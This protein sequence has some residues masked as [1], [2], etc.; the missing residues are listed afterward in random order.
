MKDLFSQDSMAEFFVQTIVS[1]WFVAILLVALVALF[2]TS[3]KTLNATTRHN[4]WLITLVSFLLMPILAF[5]PKPQVNVNLLELLTVQN[6]EVGKNDSLVSV[7]LLLT[8]RVIQK[9]KT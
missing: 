5:I 9:L 6:V 4:I 3:R 1:H 8:L 7:I 2:V